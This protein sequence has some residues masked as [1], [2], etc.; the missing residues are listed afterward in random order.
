MWVRLFQEA[1]FS[2]TVD[3]ENIRGFRGD[4]G[5]EGLLVRPW[6]H[7]LGGMSSR[8]GVFIEHQALREEASGPTFR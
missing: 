6:G 5:G 2:N 4:T 3:S 7:T 8:V 1:C